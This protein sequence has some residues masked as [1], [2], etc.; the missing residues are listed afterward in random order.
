ITDKD[1][2]AFAWQS[3]PDV[4]EAP[5]VR[6]EETGELVPTSWSEA[7]A[8]AAQGLAEAAENGGVGVLPGGRLTLE[9]A[10]AWSKFA[11]VVLGTNDVDFRARAHSAEEAQFLGHAVA[12]TGMGVTF[13]DL[14][15]AP[16]VLL[17][18]L[19]PEEEA[20]TIFLRLRKAV[21]AQKTSVTTVAPFATR[22]S[23]KMRA[24]VVTTEPGGETEA[25]TPVAA[26]EADHGP[27][28]EALSAPGAVVLV[29][30][31]LAQV[32]GGL[33]AAL[34]LAEATGARLA[35]VPRRA[36]DRGA[37]EAGLLPGL[38][39]G[40]RPVTDAEARVDIASAW[41][42]EG[43]LPAEPGRDLTGIL[44]AAGAGELGGLL[45]GGVDVEDLPGS[46]AA[47]QAVRDAG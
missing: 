18:G 14:E 47:E 17:V 3:L 5:L 19:E 25:L 29:G 43:S 33:T 2:F 26:G 32:P 22:G 13:N 23:V 34:A 11:R 9:D 44:A 45:L 8:L 31:R 46:G 12:G 20:G 40:G 24:A 39:P 38:L 42:V 6:D 41:G 27:L 7:I 16:H 28:R 15:A 37:V 10:Y 21:L 1:R 4:L 30:E 35:W 36:G